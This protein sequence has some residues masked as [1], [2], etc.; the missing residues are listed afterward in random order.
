MYLHVPGFSIEVFY[1]LQKMMEFGGNDIYSCGIIQR[2][3][4]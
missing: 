1:T 3:Y 2:L 4:M